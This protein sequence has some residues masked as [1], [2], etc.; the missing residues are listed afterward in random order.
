[1]RKQEKKLNKEEMAQNVNNL[2][3]ENLDLKDIEQSVVSFL[4]NDKRTALKQTIMEV[5]NQEQA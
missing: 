1:M 5:M 4:S 2:E 3:L